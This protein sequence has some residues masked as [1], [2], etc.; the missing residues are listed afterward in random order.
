MKHFSILFVLLIFLI[1][2]NTSTNAGGISG[3][4]DDLFSWAKNS[5]TL[6]NK[7]HVANNVQYGPRSKNRVDV[8]YN[9]QDTQHLKPVVI[10]LH[11]GAW[12]KG[13]KYNFIEIGSYLS[14]NNYV[15]FLPNYTLF[16]EGNIEDMVD[17]IHRIIR[18]V[19]YY[20]YIYGG[21]RDR[22]TLVG[23]SAGAH[24]ASLTIVKTALQLYN[25]NEA[26]GILPQLEKVVLFS[27]PYG[28]KIVNKFIDL[29][30]KLVG[31]ENDEERTTLARLFPSLFNSNDVT[32]TNILKKYVTSNNVNLNLYAP[33]MVFYW[34]DKDELVP[35]SSAN[36][37]MNEI[38]RVSPN[39]VIQYVCDR[40][41]QRTHDTLLIGA[42]DGNERLQKI[43][44]DI[45]R[46]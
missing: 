13:D 43:L 30:S 19:W 9:K 37:L 6:K 38:R 41:N 16:P 45:I 8:Y 25:Q 14:K 42:R 21:D 11:G 2:F 1:S 4:V 40:G 20:G 5:G 17:D 27:G 12:F 39:T 26:L 24:I 35:E 3:M 23:Y 7:N 22:I 32:P 18:W 46:L 33:K 29:F 31:G 36:D 44:L 10:F 15:A 34:S 28:L